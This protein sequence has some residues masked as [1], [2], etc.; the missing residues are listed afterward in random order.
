MKLSLI[1]VCLVAFCPLPFAEA[2]EE[3][4]FVDVVQVPKQVTQQAPRRKIHPE[5]ARIAL[6]PEA[7]T[8]PPREQPGWSPRRFSRPPPL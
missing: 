8:P 4:A 7:P 5:P 2:P 1:V 6:S 3:D